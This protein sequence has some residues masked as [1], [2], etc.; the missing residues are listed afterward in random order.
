MEHGRSELRARYYRDQLA[1]A[2][3]AA[4]ALRSS[5]ERVRP[6]FPLPDPIPEGLA[7]ELEALTARFARL[8]DLLV[9]KL[10]RAQDAL[11]LEDEGSL[12]DRLNRAEKRGQIASAEQWREIRELRNQIAHE[13]VLEDLRE[14]FEA[15]FRR[16]PLLLDAVER[17]WKDDRYPG[18]AGE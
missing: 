15:V 2:G 17:A 13:Y 8:A 5:Y 7:V 6:R 16:A 11:L 12:L 10:F 3:R 4:A 14:L 9:Q 18:A 1:A